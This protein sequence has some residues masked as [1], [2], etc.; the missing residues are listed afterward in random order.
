MSIQDKERTF[1]VEA[2]LPSGALPD[3]EL[4]WLKSLGATS[5]T[6]HDAWLE[7]L[8][9]VGFTVGTLQDRQSAWLLSLGH[10]QRV[11]V[12]QFYEF[13]AGNGGAGVSPEVQLVFDRMS[14]LTQIEMNAIEAFVDGMVVEGMWDDVFEFYSPCLNAT[15]YLTGFKT[16]TLQNS[17]PPPAHTPGQFITF[18]NN[19][20]HI[21]EGRNFDTY[22][23]QDIFQGAYV[24]MTAA[25]TTGNTDIYGLSAGGADTYMR[26]RGDDTNDFN[27]HVG[28]TSAANRSAA[29][30]R[31]TGDFVGLGRVV[32]QTYNL[33]PLGPTL[34]A[35]QA[36]VAHPTGFPI[37]WHGINND[38]TPATGNMANSTYSCMIAMASPAIADVGK[39]RNLVLLYLI[40]IGVTGVPIP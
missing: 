20:Q 29:N 9:I 4:A 17:I 21:L 3:M 2:G 30:L 27:E 23:T 24:V 14:A 34:I 5:N 19:G 40:A 6:I 31:P 37:Q 1:I 12:D 13:W 11:L 39:V 15:D 33:Q 28:Q 25:D 35:I 18:A 8:T 10:V 16:D 32:N 22:S 38:G 36:F 7:Y 26:W